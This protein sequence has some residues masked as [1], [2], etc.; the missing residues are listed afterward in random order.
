MKILLSILCVLIFTL[1][2]FG[3]TDN[4]YIQ[5]TIGKQ[6]KD[7]NNDVFSEYYVFPKVETKDWIGK[8]FLFIPQVKS[9]QKYGYN[10]VNITADGTIYFQRMIK[11]MTRRFFK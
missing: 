6:Q 7:S 8:R 1:A 11:I 10:L 3:Q 4:P 2:A 5:P 9:S